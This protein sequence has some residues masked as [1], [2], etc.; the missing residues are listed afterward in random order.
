M[1]HLSDADL[2]RLL[3]GKAPSDTRD[4]EAL[5]IFFQEVKSRYV[6]EP[7]A[8][9]RQAHLSQIVAAAQLN[10]RRTQPSLQASTAAGRRIPVEVKARP[11]ES[12]AEAGGGAEIHPGVPPAV[13]GDDRGRTPRWRKRLVFGS[14]FGGS[15]TAK[16]A[17]IGV[18][19]A[20]AATGG[21]AAAGS[22]PSSLQSAVAGAAG[23]VGVRLPNPQA[24]ARAN[25]Q[26]QAGKVASTVESIVRQVATAAER[27]APLTAS[28]VAST[29]ACTQNVSA[30]ASQ[31]LDSA[32]GAGGPTLVQSL[33]ERATALAQESVGCALPAIVTT[34]ASPPAGT[35]GT[36]S[37]TARGA[38][39]AKAISGAVQGCSGPLTAAIQKLVQAAIMARTAAQLQA[40]AEDAK[41]LVTA[42]RGCAQQVGSALQGALSGVPAV[43]QSGTGTGH[44]PAPA[45]GTS[46][47]ASTSGNSL[48]GLW[49]L[50]PNLPGG[51]PTVVPTA[52]APVPKRTS[53]P[54][55]APWWTQF[56]PQM[57]SQ[58]PVPSTGLPST[59]LPGTSP[60]PSPSS[61]SW[62][63]LT[64]SWNG[65]GSWSPYPSAPAS[66][67]P[68]QPEQDH[69]IGHH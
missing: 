27:P 55:P 69:Q 24:N 65:S 26:A 39:A 54:S 5:V 23:N 8:A 15:I 33:A 57:P 44:T 38:A 25:A 64:G 29:R 2:D 17:I 40:L 52:V 18:V 49:N 42:A 30:I 9:T 62:S 47:T 50:V 16:I 37:D 20:T 14:I 4:A 66:P 48:N 43:P 60:N 7:P 22:L 61:G 21:L 28:T 1:A 51:V 67:G 58:T 41:A 36:A 12:A 68:Q 35:G 46:G 31:L 56:L 45:G 63:G 3:A 34:P 32:A 13:Q 19:A 6:A 59:G 53:T 11:A 10:A